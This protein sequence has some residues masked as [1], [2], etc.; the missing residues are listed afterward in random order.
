MVVL[1]SAT[2]PDQTSPEGSDESDAGAGFKFQPVGDQG[3]IPQPWWRQSKPLKWTLFGTAAVFIG[4]GAVVITNGT[5]A[6]D[7]IQAPSVVV[8][9]DQANPADSSGA[10]GSV[11]TDTT[12]ED[13]GDATSDAT[14]T[15]S[16]AGTTTNSVTDPLGDQYQSFDDLDPIDPSRTSDGVS[17]Q[18]VWTRPT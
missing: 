3:Y 1:G 17:G 16:A 11:S 15:S 6:T 10:S 2:P 4:V 8:E 14:K 5:E 9:Q 13:S 12:A 18:D 7:G